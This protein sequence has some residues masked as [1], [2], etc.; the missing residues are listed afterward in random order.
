ML[1]CKNRDDDKLL[2]SLDYEALLLMPLPSSDF[3]DLAASSTAPEARA[4]DLIVPPDVCCVSMQLNHAKSICSKSR[5]QSMEPLR[6]CPLRKPMLWKPTSPK[7]NLSKP[8]LSIDE[9]SLEHN[10]LIFPDHETCAP[11][12]TLSGTSLHSLLASNRKRQAEL[13]ASVGAGP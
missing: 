8:I 11:A 10:N 9:R 3:Y 5:V 13:R 2:P 1:D 6:S 4:L 7:P 12:K